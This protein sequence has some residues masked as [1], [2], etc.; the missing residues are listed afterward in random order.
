MKTIDKDEFKINNDKLQFLSDLFNVD[1]T[2]IERIYDCYKQIQDGMKEQYLSHVI[3]TMEYQLQELTG[4][5]MFKITTEKM[6][7]L[8]SKLDVGCASYIK[9]CCFSIYYD[10]NMTDKQL[11]ICLAHELGH[12]Y[13][14]EYLNNKGYNLNEKDNTEPLSSIFGI[15]TILDKNDFYHNVK[16]KKLMHNTFKD[17]TRDFILMKN[18]DNSIFNLS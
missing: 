1:V 17:L 4:N 10:P 12:L 16:D 18:R 11:R 3:R 8:K 6:P 14:I 15:F 5:P 7:A 9:G 13:L 2:L